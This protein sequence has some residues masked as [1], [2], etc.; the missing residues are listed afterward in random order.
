MGKLETLRTEL[1]KVR[2]QLNDKG[3]HYIPGESELMEIKPFEIKYQDVIERIW[4]DDA[5]W[6]VTHYWDIFDA[7]MNGLSDE[8]VIDEIC[9]HVGQ[10]Y[11]KESKEDVLGACVENN[12]TMKEYLDRF[13][14]KYNDGMLW[15]FSEEDFEDGSIEIN[16]N[17]VYWHIK[18]LDGEWRYFETDIVCEKE[19]LD[20]EKKLNEGTSNFARLDN[21]PLLVFYTLDEFDYM[22]K[23]DSDYPQEY[24][25]ED[26]DGHVDENAYWDAV[27]KFEQDFWDKNNVCVLDEDEQER[28]ENKLYD[29]NQES[30]RMAWDADYDEKEGQMYGDN[31]NLEDIEITIEP[32]YYSAAQLYIEHEDYFDY[33]EGDFRIK[34]I[35]RFE[36]FFEELRKEFGLTK[37]GVAWGPASNGETGYKILNDSL[38]ECGELDEKKSK[39]KYKVNFTGDPAKNAAFFNHCQ[40]ADS[41]GETSSVSLGEKKELKEGFVGQVVDDFI[42]IIV[43]PDMIETLVI[44]NIDADD[45][46]EAFKGVEADLSDEL[47][48]ADYADFDTGGDKL[49]VNVSSDEDDYGDTYYTTLGELLDDYNGDEVEVQEYGEVLFDGDKYDIDDELLEKVFIS[50]DT[51]KYLCI[52]AHCGEVVDDEFDDDHM[53]FDNAQEAYDYLKELAQDEEYEFYDIVEDTYEYPNGLCLIHYADKDQEEEIEHYCVEI[54][55]SLKEDKCNEAFEEIYIKYWEDEELRDQGISEIYTDNFAT[56]EEAIEVARKLVD[57]DGFASVEVF[58]CPSGTLESEDDQLIWGYDGVDTWGLGKEESLKEESV[59]VYALD[60]Y[61]YD[62]ETGKKSK[63]KEPAKNIEVGTSKELDKFI[64]SYEDSWNS[65]RKDGLVWKFVKRYIGNED[66]K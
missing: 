23:N 16:P 34:Q 36:K 64:K 26:E 6:Q 60:A 41:Y 49:V 59:K 28:L 46:H 31:L 25:F 53:I 18:D 55:E 61:L 7:M 66:R 42:N 2:K 35:E 50:I 22:L 39:K 13:G 58:V 52:N 33:L 43:E 56:R 30:K 14:D 29:F 32:G 57:R 63:D 37:L 3:Y 47:R 9:K 5:W 4:P 20:E 21:F 65:D 15:D 24:N 44:S 54:R 62:A 19:S 8:E 38:K 48:Q 10:D 40:G 12:H 17:I 1:E 51:P 11:L 45:Y 27:E